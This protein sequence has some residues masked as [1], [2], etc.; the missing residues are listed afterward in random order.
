MDVYRGE[1]GHVPKIHVAGANGACGDNVK[2]FDETFQYAIEKFGSYQTW[3]RKPAYEYVEA[4]G[5]DEAAQRADAV[6]VKAMKPFIVI[7]ASNQN[8]GAPVFEAEMANAKII[9]NGA[10]AS[11]LTTAELQ[12]QA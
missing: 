6:K 3:G 8:K 10:A 1:G 9:V 11:A 2:D 4:S 12:K 5:P 7:D